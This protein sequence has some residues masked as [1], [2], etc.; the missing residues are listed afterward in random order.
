MVAACYGGMQF[1]IGG[2]C[3]LKVALGCG[4][5]HRVCGECNCRLLDALELCYYWGM[6]LR[7]A[8]RAGL[9]V[10]VPRFWGNG[11]LL[12]ALQWWAEGCA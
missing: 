1:H 12:D 10:V 2:R 7:I 6:Q 3:G 9:Q 11:A 8:R 4:W 5:R